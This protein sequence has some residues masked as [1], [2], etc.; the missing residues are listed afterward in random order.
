MLSDME[1]CP[2]WLWHPT[3]LNQGGCMLGTGLAVVQSP[4]GG[5]VTVFYQDDKGLICQRYA[6]VFF[7][8]VASAKMV[9]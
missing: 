1:W 4:D 9:V 2:T 6:E 3:L 5:R 8:D 7:P